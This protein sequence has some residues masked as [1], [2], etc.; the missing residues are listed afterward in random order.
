MPTSYPPMQ[1]MIFMIVDATRKF[2]ATESEWLS[3][4][5]PLIKAPLASGGA[6][7]IIFG[8]TRAGPTTLLF[9]QL[10]PLCHTI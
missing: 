3:G 10:S 5:S 6:T 9:V 1:A 7:V 2:P 4:S 8:Y